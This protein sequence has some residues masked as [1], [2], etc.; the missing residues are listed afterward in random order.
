MGA[1]ETPC[2]AFQ[3]KACERD[4]KPHRQK[5]PS[6][7]S[8]LG[9]PVPGLEPHPSRTGGEDQSAQ[10][11]DEKSEVPDGVVRIIGETEES[12]KQRYAD[13]EQS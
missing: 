12:Q 5:G 9:L 11:Q 6:D 10:E 8:E 7:D 3:K 13:G 4:Y 1:A 2:L